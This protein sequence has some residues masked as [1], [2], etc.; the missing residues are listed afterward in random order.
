MFQVHSKVVSYTIYTYTTFEIIFHHK[1]LQDIDYNTLHYMVNIFCYVIQHLAFQQ[2]LQK[3]QE[4][5]S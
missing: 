2:T 5:N 4:V 3:L 1:L